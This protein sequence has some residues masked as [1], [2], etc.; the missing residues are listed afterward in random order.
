M[1]YTSTKRP[2]WSKYR[3]STSPALVTYSTSFPRFFRGVFPA[4]DDGKESMSDVK[5][6]DSS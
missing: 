5:A 3:H 6:T 4:L 2:C 1:R